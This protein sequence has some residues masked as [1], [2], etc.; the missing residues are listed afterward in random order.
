MLPLFSVKGYSPW[1]RAVQAVARDPVMLKP[2]P[3][4]ALGVLCDLRGSLGQPQVLAVE[5]CVLTDDCKPPTS[6][7]MARYYC[8]LRA[9][10]FGVLRLCI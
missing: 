1:G 5:G 8:W 2:P 3:S 6:C 4:V 9:V 7:Q 10:I